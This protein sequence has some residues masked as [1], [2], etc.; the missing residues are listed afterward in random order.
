MSTWHRLA[1]GALDSQR[2]PIRNS[3]QQIRPGSWNASDVG[4]PLSGW[5]R[6]RT[7]NRLPQPSGRTA[8]ARSAAAR[9]AGCQRLGPSSPRSPVPPAMIRR[10]VGADANVSS[11]SNAPPWRHP[12]E[13]REGSD[14]NERRPAQRS[15]ERAISAGGISAPLNPEKNRQAFSKQLPVNALRLRCPVTAAKRPLAPASEHRSGRHR[16]V[17]GDRNSVPGIHHDR[18]PADRRRLLVGQRSVVPC[19]RL[20]YRQSSDLFR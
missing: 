18:E 5:P 2:L 14:T 19:P 9:R 10:A 1:G 12:P 20:R 7:E 8:A 3:Q 16:V 13:S 4:A 11:S 17:A 6:T 15:S